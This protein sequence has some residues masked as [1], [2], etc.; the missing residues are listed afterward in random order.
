MNESPSSRSH[1]TPL[2][3]PCVLHF[4]S[5][6][7]HSPTRRKTAKLTPIKGR[8]A[9]SLCVTSRIILPGPTN[10]W[11][12]H[13][14]APLPRGTTRASAWTRVAYAT[15][16]RSVCHLRL[17]WARAALP[18]GDASASHPRGPVCHVSPARP[19][20]PHQHRGPA[21][22]NPTF[23]AILITKYT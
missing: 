3:T 22:I 2:T 11:T 4:K 21:E 19:C 7:E 8:G 23:F 14:L 18:H 17:T 13:L 1:L 16:L 20:A 9:V 6:G 10:P 15:C 5:I 12:L